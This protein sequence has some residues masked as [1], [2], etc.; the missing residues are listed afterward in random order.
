M[1][2]LKKFGLEVLFLIVFI[3]GALFCVLFDVVLVIA[4]ILLH[5]ASDILREF[6]DDELDT[7]WDEMIDAIADSVNNIREIIRTAKIEL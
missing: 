2:K 3:L 4:T 7:L 6:S 1:N 5:W